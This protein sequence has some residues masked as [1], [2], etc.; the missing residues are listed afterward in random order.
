MRVQ[1]R[2]IC[3]VA[4]SITAFSKGAVAPVE[5]GR[6]SLATASPAACSVTTGPHGLAEPTDALHSWVP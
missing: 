6:L 5:V 3:G 1:R 4:V 2:T